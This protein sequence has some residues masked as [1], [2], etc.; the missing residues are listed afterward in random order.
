M[1]GASELAGGLV[2]PGGRSLFLHAT[3]DAY[4]ASILAGQNSWQTLAALSEIRL[5]RIK[6]RCPG[7]AADLGRIHDGLRAALGWVCEMTSLEAAAAPLPSGSVLR[8]DFDAFPAEPPRYFGA[9][10]NHLGLDLAH[11][12]AR[13]ICEG[14]LMRRYSKALEYDYGPEDRRATLAESR[15]RNVRALADALDWLGGLAS[16]YPAVAQAIRRSRGDG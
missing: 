11:G 16:R 9:I 12:Q 2:Q 10:A 6:G 1:I 3:P 8:L 13:A 15:A 7:L 4:L 5:A 14:P